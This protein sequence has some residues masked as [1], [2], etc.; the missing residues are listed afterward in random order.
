MLA[1]RSPVPYFLVL[2]GLVASS[3]AIGVNTPGSD[4]TKATAAAP[5]D[6]TFGRATMS[7]IQGAGFEPGIRVDSAGRIYTHS[8]NS[9]SSGTSWIWISKDGGKTYKWVPAAAPKEESCQP[10]PEAVTV[11]SPSIPAGIST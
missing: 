1:R 9:L 10:V 3:V 6:P 7:S 5:G 4:V 8:P 11:R 2:L